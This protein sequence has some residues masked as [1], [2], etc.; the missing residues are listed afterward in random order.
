MEIIT[1]NI[2]PVKIGWPANSRLAEDCAPLRD[3]L[4]LTGEKGRLTSPYVPGAVFRSVRVRDIAKFLRSG[5]YDLGILGDDTGSEMDLGISYRRFDVGAPTE[6]TFFVKEEERDQQW[7]NPVGKVLTQYPNL[8]R[9]LTDPITDGF[10]NFGNVEFSDEVDG[11]IESI[12]RNGDIPNVIGGMDIVRTGA[13]MRSYGLVPVLRL[14]KSR[15]GLWKKPQIPEAQKS[16]I[17]DVFEIMSSKLSP[18]LS[19]DF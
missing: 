4:G 10:D 14:L 13:T 2:E 12:V 6:F 11:Q 5:I 15:P 16:Q 17:E 18:F 9:K 19:T 3:A 8:A 7:P 1:N